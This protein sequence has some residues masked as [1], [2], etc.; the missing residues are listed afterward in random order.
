MKVAVIIVTY[1]SEVHIHK[2]IECLFSQNLQPTKIIVVDT[3][4]NDPSYLE[5]YKTHSHVEIV[6]APKNSGFCKG[7][8]I[9]MESV[10]ADSEAVFFLN[11]DAFL[12]PNYLKLAAETLQKNPNVGALTGLTLGYEISS[13]KPTGRYDTTGVFRSWYGRWYDRAQGNSVKEDLYKN[14]EVIPAIC[15]AVFFCRKVALDQVLLRGKEAFDATFYMYKEDVDLSIR[16][17]KQG[18]DLLFNPQ[19]IAYHCRGWN[20]QRSLMPRLFRKLSA[21][22]EIRVNFRSRHPIGIL[23]SSL[24]LSLVHLLDL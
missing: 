21:K 6:L 15:G 18:W 23:Y 24:K 8:N 16:L 12:T 20:S 14:G 7:N 11:P 10:P 9:G 1:N 13:D 2:A 19:L 5:K 3:G 4:S 22:N 17:R